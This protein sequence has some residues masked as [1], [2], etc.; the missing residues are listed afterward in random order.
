M[1]ITFHHGI[2]RRW[3]LRRLEANNVSFQSVKLQSSGDEILENY[4][5]LLVGMYFKKFRKIFELIFRGAF[6]GALTC[7]TEITPYFTI[8]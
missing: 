6:W 2:A 5:H 8:F 3:E 4:D 1:T 7:V